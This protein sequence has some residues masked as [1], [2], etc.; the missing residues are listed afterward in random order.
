MEKIRR[1]LSQAELELQ[2]LERAE[3]NLLERKEQSLVDFK[4]DSRRTALQL[5]ERFTKN[6]E[7]NKASEATLILA[8]AELIYHW[9]VNIPEKDDLTLLESFFKTGMLIKNA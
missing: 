3:K 2:S 4:R 5:S 9:L 7:G 1:V 8:N 6:G